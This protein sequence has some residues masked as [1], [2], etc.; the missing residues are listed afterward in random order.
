MTPKAAPVPRTTR[1]PVNVLIVGVGGQG[2]L[3]ASEALAEAA[4][5]KGL[6]IKKSEVHGMAQRGGSV[7]SHVR[8][9]RRVY[10]PLIPRGEADF[11]VS[12]EKLEALRY[13][14]YLHRDS[15]A[16]VNDQEI[17]PLPV[18]TGRA[19]YPKGID[20]VIRKAGIRCRMVDGIGLAARSGNVRAVN[21]VILGVLSKFLPFDIETWKKA[22]Q[23]HVPERHLDANLKAFDLGRRRRISMD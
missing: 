23:L 17:Y 5:M 18:S 9:G 16:L 22:L 12:F 19:E 8:F 21:S 10:S 4:A 15:W 13:L 2:V 6:Q 3:L 1:K 11:L 14:E 20:R 7:V